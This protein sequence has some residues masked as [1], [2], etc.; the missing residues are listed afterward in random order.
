[1]ASMTGDELRRAF[2]DFFVAR[3]HVEVPSASLIPH[4]TSVLFTVAG[5]VPFKPY[6]TGEEPA[7]Y[8]KATSCQKCVRAGGKHNDL[9]DVGRTNRHFSFFEMLGNFSFG[10]YFKAE[11]IPLAWELYTEHLGLDPDRMWVTIHETDDEAGRIWRDDVG[12]PAARVQR[13]G[14]DNFWRMADTGPCGP[15]S[16]IFWDLGPEYGPDGGPA[17]GGANRFVEIWNLVFMQWDAQ[18]D[19]TLLPLPNP[20]VDTGAGLERNLAVLQRTP[21]IWD[22]DLFA[23]LLGAAESVTGARYQG[24]PGTE[25]D[26]SLRIMAEHARTM[27][28]LVAD[29]VVPSNEERGYV[30]RRMIRRAVRHAYRLGARDL[31]TPALVDATVG[32]M[33][34]AYPDL[35]THHELVTTVI[36][37]EEERFR[38]TLQR[39]EE[40]LDQVLAEGDISGERAFFLHDT[41]GYPVD[42]TREVAAERGRD[43]DVA[44]FDAQMQQQRAR[45]REAHKAAGGAAAAPV[46]LYRELLDDE[47][48]TEFTGRQ[49]YSTAG[50]RVLAIV[51][52]GARL[53][54]ATAAD[55]G[56]DV[57]LDR[58][59]FYAESGGQVGD[60]GTLTGADGLRVVVADA[61]HA[62]PGILTAHRSRVEEGE[63][64]EGDTVTAAI[65]GPRRDAIRRNHTATH[66]LHWALR[67]VLGTHVKQAGS[68]VAPDRLRFDFSHFEA[69]TQEQL[70]EIE[71]LANREVISDARVRHYETTKEHA[72]E[73]G[74]I[75]FFGDKYG[76]VVRVLEAGE[77]SL[78]LCGGTHVHALG[79][80]G[81]I[82]IVSEGSI[83]SNLRRIEAVTGEGALERVH[84]EEVQLRA[85]AGL[86]N[87]GA[88]EV[89]ERVERLLVQ[90]KTLSDELDRARAREAGAEAKDLAAAAV[91]GV[92]AVRRDGLSGDALRLLALATRDALGSGIVVI[93]GAAPAGDKASVAVAVS[94][95]LVAAG[96]SAAAIGRP[97]A[98]VL[99]GGTGKNEDFVQGGGPKVDALDEALRVAR[100]RASTPAPPP[101]SAG[102]ST[103][104]PPPPSA[105]SS[106]PA[107][108]PPSAGSGSSEMGRIL[109]VDLGSVRIGLALSDP[110]GTLASPFAVLTRTGDA[111]ADR[112]AIVAAAREGEAD[113]IVVGMPRSLDGGDGPAARAAREEV[114]ALRTEAGAGL[115]VDVHDERLTTVIAERSLVESG[116]R[117]RDRK[118]VVDKVA[119][120]VMLQS[121]LDAQ[122]A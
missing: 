5:M 117:R 108:P 23:P 83:G 39:G 13:L 6:F 34:S 29:G 57:F 38:A 99:G 85:V 4:D 68:L 111:A 106:T 107:P 26:V 72:E 71:A 89:P 74:A 112:R 18:P 11:A 65:D 80:I 12:V 8:A 7:P 64:R 59:P 44:G 93:V 75:A 28:F 82:K 21:S 103:P 100:E 56:I 2:L 53:A 46:E 98:Q 22:I 63:L 95:D 119:A 88:T 122:R 102:S 16:E 96:V 91:G 90:V 55:G 35:A 78:E 101:P 116:V 77:H 3:G 110:T 76:D 42:L 45:A 115:T 121:Y 70:D 19:G 33:S 15:S 10:D 114:A 118:Q 66:V 60:T 58:T 48:P 20:S 9:D 62:I 50:A 40:L 113:G 81:P 32:V 84:D 104:A 79:F 14:D 67:E 41:L 17:H 105:G 86:L 94:R 54:R 87:V 61:Q 109:G 69:L 25:T 73:L 120:A 36:R 47:G 37:R 51:R 49:E 52:D 43:V 31:V 1:M 97:A 92:V 27:T 30:L 24:F